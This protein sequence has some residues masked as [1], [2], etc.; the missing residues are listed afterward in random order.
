MGS[1]TF[2]NQNPCVPSWPDVFQFDTFLSV[3]QCN[4]VCIIASFWSSSCCFVLL[5]LV[6]PFG[7]SV[8]FFLFPCFSPK[9]FCFLC[10]WSLG[11]LC[12]FPTYLFLDHSFIIFENPILFVFC[13]IP[14]Q[15]VLISF[16]S[17][18]SIDLSLRGAL[19]DFTVLFWSVPP[20]IS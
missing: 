10:I 7:L 9:L 13:L 20:K 19:P 18:I 11:C 3:A 15:Y 6:F 5:L 8:L 16:L 2:F 14:S 17:Q 1:R 12:A 4:S